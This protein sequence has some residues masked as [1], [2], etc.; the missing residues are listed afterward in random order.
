MN[1]IKLMN[2]N[3]KLIIT[4]SF[5][6]TT[7][8][9]LYYI[10]LQFFILDITKS[11][12]TTEILLGITMLP[13]LLLRPIGGAIADKLNKKTILIL[14]DII[15]GISILLVAIMLFYGYNDIAVIIMVELINRTCSSI[16]SPTNSAIL[17]FIVENSKIINCES[18]LSLSGFL[19]NIIEMLLGGILYNVAGVY[20]L[21][22]INA[23][24]FFI[25]AILES[26][27]RLPKIKQQISNINIA[28]NL[29]EGIKVYNINKALYVFFNFYNVSKFIF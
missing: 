1:E 29:K 23:I 7:G 19:P 27:L 2:K 12:V 28:L 17:P 10:A 3:F 25:S 4:G 14:M 6:S 15:R 20:Y 8:S 5:I 13:C 18:I 16:Y 11:I 26:L 9:M 22:L 24:S 21:F